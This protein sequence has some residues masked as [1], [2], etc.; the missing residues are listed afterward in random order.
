MAKANYEGASK[1]FPSIYGTADDGWLKFFQ[2]PAGFQTLGKFLGDAYTTV[3]DEED[4]QAGVKRL[5]SGRRAARRASL[6]EVLQTVFPER[7]STEPFSVSMEKL[8]AGRSQRMFAK[9]CG[10]D[11][12]TLSRYMRGE[13]EPDLTQLEKI[14]K[15]AKVHPAYFMEWRAM[16]VGHVVQEMFRKNPN[17]SITA[18]QSLLTGRKLEA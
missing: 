1:R 16:Y 10:M 15:A 6:D 13:F 5:G 7:Y 11:Q 14:A 9:K 17:L 18:V 3:K 8:L 4:R 2:S 12:T